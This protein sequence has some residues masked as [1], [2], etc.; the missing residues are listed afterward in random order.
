[1]SCVRSASRRPRRSQ[2]GPEMDRDNDEGGKEEAKSEMD[3]LFV[4]LV[5]SIG[6]KK[7]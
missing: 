1:M 4:A 6:T 5:R 2:T 3:T 7:K